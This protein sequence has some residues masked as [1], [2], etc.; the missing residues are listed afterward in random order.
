MLSALA[1]K[2]P[3]ALLGVKRNPP[4]VLVLKPNHVDFVSVT[5]G[6]GLE[7]QACSKKEKLLFQRGKPGQQEPGQSAA[8]GG[9]WGIG[10]GSSCVHEEE[11]KES[12]AFS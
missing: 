11:A 1:P 7:G 4:L 2:L 3:G 12:L 9:R 8:P 6:T 10:L 5:S